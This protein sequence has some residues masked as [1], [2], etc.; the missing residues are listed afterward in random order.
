MKTNSHGD[1]SDGDNDDGGGGGGTA[2]GEEEEDM[3][4]MKILLPP[5]PHCRRSNRGRH[6]KR[7]PQRGTAGFWAVST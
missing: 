4:V 5:S 6:S 3:I 1:D 7:R 2:A